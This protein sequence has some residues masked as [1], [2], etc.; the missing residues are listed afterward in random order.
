MAK[1]VTITVL[2]NMLELSFEENSN[3]AFHWGVV[4]GEKFILWQTI[5]ECTLIAQMVRINNF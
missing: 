2:E 4:F 1:G 3:Y 5:L